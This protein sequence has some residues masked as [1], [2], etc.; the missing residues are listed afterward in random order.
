MPF[1]HKLGK[2]PPKRHTQFRKED[3]SLY[4]EQLFGT[5]GFDGMSTNSYHE[6]RPTMVKEIRRQYSVKPKIAKANNIQS[7]RF[8]GFQVAPEN[9]YLESRKIVLTNTDCNIILAAPKEST[10]DYFYKNT[11]ADEV[12][13][14][15]KGTGKLRTMLGNINFKYGDYLVIPRGIIYK[16]DFDDQ[17]NRLFIVESYSPVYTPK[18]YRN[19]FGQLLE[20]APFC[21]RD[22]RRPQELETHNELGD[23]LINVKKQGE[24]IEMIYASHP[25]DVVGYDG[26]NYPYAFSIHDFEPITGRVHQPPP[27]HQTFETNTFVICSFVPRL[28]DYHPNA[29]PAPYNHSNI[30]S[31]EVLYYVDGDFMSRNDI[32]Q[33]HISLHPAGIPHGPHPGAA[34]RSIGHKKTE[35]LAVMVDT[36]KPLQV[37]EEAMKIADENYY[38]SWLE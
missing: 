8:R 11:D 1:Y 16:L 22:I 37:T 4:Y 13:F 29:I 32:D 12:I 5:I 19:H 31:D 6:F 7:Y 35:E 33:G 3:G 25:F 28:Y 14:I 38:K 10:T 30:D 26:Y 18:R 9:D 34:E 15:H 17:N 20:H 21:E 24:I 23:F 36:F 27:V 2:I